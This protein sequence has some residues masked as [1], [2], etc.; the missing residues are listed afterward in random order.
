MIEER[1]TRTEDDPSGSLGEEVGALA[2]H[3]HPYGQPIIGWMVDLT[4]ITPEEIQA[5]YRTYYSP[6]NAILVAVGDFKAAEVMAKIQ[7]TFGKN[8]KGAA[9][10]AGPRRRAAAER[11]ASGPGAP[12][13]PAADRLSRL[14]RAEPEVG[15]RARAGGA[16]GHPLGRPLVPALPSTSS[17][18]ASWPSR[19]AV[20]TRTS[21]SIPTC[22]GSGPPRCRARRPRRSRRSC[23]ARWTSSSASRSRP[24]SSRGP[25]TRS[26]PA[27]VFQDDS[28]HTR[29]SLLARFELIGGY[30]LRDGFLDRIRAVTAADVQRVAKLY[31]EDDKKNVGT[32]LPKP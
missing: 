12:R 17:T 1:R 13:C 24:R 3:A 10:A 2:F 27:I 32:L 16:V 11:R 19:P 18:S 7:A 21:P 30:A 4:R 22:S 23:S 9:A 31:F 25:R 15:G 8:P 29:G 28:I 14:P 5:F 6:G 26:S 20:T